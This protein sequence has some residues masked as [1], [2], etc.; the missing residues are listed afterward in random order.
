MNEEPAR[1]TTAPE[2]DDNGVDRTLVRAALAM[3]PAER[4]RHHDE[5]LAD[6]LR[7]AAAGEAAR[8]ARR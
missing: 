1:T 3:T 2:Y 7:L 4:A 6:V 8:D 5:L